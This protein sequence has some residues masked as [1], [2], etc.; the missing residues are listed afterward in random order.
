MAGL[1]LAASFRLV[2]QTAESDSPARAALRMTV[3][4][5]AP[6]TPRHAA[7][8]SASMTSLRARAPARLVTG[9]GRRVGR[10]RAR[11]GRAARHQQG[12][13]CVRSG[14]MA[15]LD[16]GD[17]IGIGAVIGR[18][19]VVGPDGDLLGGQRPLYRSCRFGGKLRRRCRR[20]RGRHAGRNSGRD[21]RRRPGWCR[22]A[23][24]ASATR[25]LASAAAID[26]NN[27]AR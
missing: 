19:H 7:A 11:R 21:D 8:T 17:E 9:L 23:R 22:W 24:H 12:G 1:V 13:G 18:H 5:V 15:R 14:Q 4:S 27:A 10:G 16:G 26:P 20:C 3:L 25:W 6:M 2:S